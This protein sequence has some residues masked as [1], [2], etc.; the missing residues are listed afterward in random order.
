MVEW[1]DSAEI[2]RA[3]EAFE[4]IIFA[5]F[6]LYLWELFMTCDFEWSLITRKRRFHWPLVSDLFPGM[7]CDDTDRKWFRSSSCC[8]DIVCCSLSS[9]CGYPISSLLVALIDIAT[10]IIS[11]S[12]LTPINCRALFTF[13]SWTGNMAILCASTCLMLR[14]I[15][16]WE[17]RVSIIAILGILCL[18]HWALLY[19][20]M[21]VVIAQWD[22]DSQSCVVTQTSPLFLNITFFFTMGF[23]FMILLFTTMALL[24]RNSPKTGLWKM[25]FHDGLV[26]FLISFT[27]NCI[28]AVLNILNLNTPMNV[29]ATVPAASIT[30]I[31]ACRAVIRLVEFR[32]SDQFVPSASFGTNQGRRAFPAAVPGK[33]TKSS[34]RPEV[35]VTTEHITM[36]E[37]P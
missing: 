1:S 36:A 17:R 31:A 3:A 14:T 7:Y 26:Y 27:M 11:L 6:G 13:N 23:D 30:S 4:K 24:G 37:F 25:L 22:D 5:F 33:P 34:T 35:H 18:A 16:L 8:A 20:G 19:R 15:A 9:A 28:P 32:S 2:A 29:I 10:R 12:A 21:F